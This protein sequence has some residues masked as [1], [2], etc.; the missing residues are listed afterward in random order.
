MSRHDEAL[1]ESRRARELDLLSPIA[2]TSLGIHL[3]YARRYDE[4]AAQQ[5]RTSSKP[6]FAPALRSLGGCWGAGSALRR[7]DRLLSARARAAPL[8]LSATTLLAHTY[9]VSGREDEARR[10]LEELNA[11]AE[12]RYVSRYRLARSTSRWARGDGP[13]ISS[14]GGHRGRDHAMVW[15]NVAP[16]FD[17]IRAEPR[18]RALIQRMRLDPDASLADVN[19]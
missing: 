17:P 5:Q 13:S 11:E 2:S 14:R 8:G 16:R 3:F 10:L 1:A 18:F 4:A 7:G 19:R 12:R 6:T 9:A 15:L